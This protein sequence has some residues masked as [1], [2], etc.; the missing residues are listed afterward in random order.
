M[1]ST[2][3]DPTDP[4]DQPDPTNL[5]KKTTPPPASPAKGPNMAREYRRELRAL[6][7]QI[8]KIQT[9]QHRAHRAKARDIA[10]IENLAV[11]QIRAIHR[12]ADKLD[13]GSIKQAQALSKRQAILIGR[14]S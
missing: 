10:R 9:A 7:T 3:K 5:M 8:R 11:A 13:R 6:G 4:T 14:L 1:E 12:A 2:L